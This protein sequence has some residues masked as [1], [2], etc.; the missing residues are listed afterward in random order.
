MAGLHKQWLTLISK[1]NNVVKDFYISRSLLLRISISHWTKGQKTSRKIGSRPKLDRIYTAQQQ[2]FSSKY[3]S[4]KFL[5]KK[6]FLDKNETEKRSTS[7]KLYLRKFKKQMFTWH[8]NCV[9]HKM[10]FLLLSICI[11]MFII[12]KI[13]AYLCYLKML[14][15]L[16]FQRPNT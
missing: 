6:S 2:D 11:F 15:Q 7:F 14:H 10:W 4:R 16:D 3:E 5:T 12:F 8:M 1:T 9:Y 13:Y